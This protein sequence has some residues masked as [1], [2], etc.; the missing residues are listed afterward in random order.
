MREVEKRQ[1]FGDDSEEEESHKDF[2]PRVVHDMDAY[3]YLYDDVDAPAV[4]KEDLPEPRDQDD[5][6]GPTLDGKPM[7]D[8]AKNWVFTAHGPCASF[9]VKE[10]E[11]APSTPPEPVGKQIK[12]VFEFEDSGKELAVEEVVKTVDIRAVNEVTNET[13]VAI[14]GGPNHRA[15]NVEESDMN[16]TGFEAHLCKYESRN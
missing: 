11:S 1:V 16:Y 6:I 7:E 15:G 10:V 8:R 14:A 5:F 9:E 3:L 4:F 2:D 13:L 12:A